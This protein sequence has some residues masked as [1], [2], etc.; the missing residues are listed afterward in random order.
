MKLSELAFTGD[1]FVYDWKPHCWTA[2]MLV[3]AQE[4]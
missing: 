1:S 3:L 4:S 2:G